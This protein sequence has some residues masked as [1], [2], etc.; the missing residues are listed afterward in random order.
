MGQVAE[1]LGVSKRTLYRLIADGSLPKPVKV[2][3]CSR[4]VESELTVFIETLK[5]KRRTT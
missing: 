2:G 3:S 1:I 5:G 4:I